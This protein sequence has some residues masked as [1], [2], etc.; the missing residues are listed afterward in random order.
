MIRE[1]ERVELINQQVCIN[2]GSPKEIDHHIVPY[3]KGGRKTIP[4]CNDCHIKIHG[5]KLDNG[6]L[7][8]LGL[9]KKRRRI[10]FNVFMLIAYNEYDLNEIYNYSKDYVFKHK[11]TLNRFI[12]S[13]IKIDVEDL[14]DLFIPMM[15][16]SKFKKEAL[17]RA[18]KQ[19]PNRKKENERIYNLVY[20]NERDHYRNLWIK[21]I[22]K[23]KLEKYE[24]AN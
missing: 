14:L 5:V 18:N 2:C 24:R 17:K 10:G 3:L 11:T 6:Y 19:H 23:F 8:R 12:N 22:E 1:K 7:S 16:L 9:L 15:E 4:L 20:G 21:N 13:M